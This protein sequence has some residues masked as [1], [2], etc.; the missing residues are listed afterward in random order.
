M[1]TIAQAKDRRAAKIARKQAT[2]PSPIFEPMMSSEQAPMVQAKCACGGGCP[3]CKDQLPIHAKLAVSEPG[4][5]YEQEADRIADQVM[6]TPAHPAPPSILRFS[7]QW[8]GHMNAAPTSVDQ[9]LASPGRPLEPA[10]RND[11]EQRFGHDFSSVRVHSGAA[12]EQ[13]ARDANAR[14]YTAG[15]NIVFGADGF[16]PSTQEGRKLLAHELTHVLQ[17]SNAGTSV[18][19]KDSPGAGGFPTKAPS[20]PRGKDDQEQSW[21]NPSISLS[22]E[23][24]L[25]ATI[26]FRTKEFS[27]DA[28]DKAVLLQLAKAYAPWAKSRAGASGPDRR[29]RR[30]PPVGRAE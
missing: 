3:G 22:T 19:R 8:K 17:Q 28:K 15:N 6:A 14:A 1:K 24:V 18:Q 27:L 4:D 23:P 5:I 16:T 10:L 13:S 2:A 9:V 11:M 21:A 26:Y 30:S 20:G 25:V 7:G 29:L 12:A